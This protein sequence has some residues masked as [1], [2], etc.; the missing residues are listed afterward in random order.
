MIATFKSKGLEELFRDGRTKRINRRFHNRLLKR[1]ELLNEIS[2]PRLIPTAW[3]CHPRWQ[4]SDTFQ[5]DVSGPWRL[6]FRFRDGS[7]YDVDFEQTH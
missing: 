2:H 4:G 7:F 6:L 3:D 1:L 5:V